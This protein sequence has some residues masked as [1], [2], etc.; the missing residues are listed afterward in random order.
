M[1]SSW[2]AVGDGS[3][4]LPLPTHLPQALISGLHSSNKKTKYLPQARHLPTF[5]STECWALM[6]LESPSF[7]VILSSSL[8]SSWQH[9]SHHVNI[10]LFHPLPL[11]CALL[12]SRNNLLFILS[13]NTKPLKYIA[14][15][16][17]A[18][19]HWSV[20]R[21]KMH[22]YCDFERKKLLKSKKKIS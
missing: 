2:R 8:N 13:S 20:G 15:H 18:K 10:V 9:L 22:F 21:N 7:S 3:H 16:A 4:F 17:E 14:N 12:T 5:W 6:N 1:Y 11:L 19:K